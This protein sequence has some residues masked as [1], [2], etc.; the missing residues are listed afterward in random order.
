MG[1]RITQEGEAKEA[2][3]HDIEQHEQGQGDT[4]IHPASGVNGRVWQRRHLGNEVNESPNCNEIK[5]ADGQQEVVLA[6]IAQTAHQREKKNN[7]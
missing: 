1:R 7:D 6:D 5:G 3:Q 2:R 4:V